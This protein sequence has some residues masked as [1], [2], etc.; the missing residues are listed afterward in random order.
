MPNTGAAETSATGR[1]YVR[2]V[3]EEARF[4]IVLQESADGDLSGVNIYL[5]SAGQLE[6]LRVLARLGPSSRH[7][8]LDELLTPVEGDR[9]IV[10]A[11]VVFTDGAADLAHS[12]PDA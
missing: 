2:R 8:H 6:L 7:A 9:E 4:R 1:S 12:P 11:N 10:S 3:T 5:N